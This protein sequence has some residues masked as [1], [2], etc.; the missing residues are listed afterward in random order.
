MRARL[1]EQDLRAALER[2][3]ADARRRSRA[4]RA[5]RQPRSRASASARAHRAR[6]RSP[7][8]RCPPERHA[9][10]VDH[11]A[12]RQLARA[13]D[14]RVADRDRARCAS[15]SAWIEGPPCSRIAPATPAPSTSW[16]FAAFTIA[17]T[18][19]A[20]MSPST[21][22]DAPAHRRASRGA[23]RSAPAGEQRQQDLVVPDQRDS[24][25]RRSASG[26]RPRSPA[27]R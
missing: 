7:R 14:R 12:G 22:H 26:A 13:G 1:L 10:R 17:S 2:E 23:P 25:G 18:A 19:C 15:H 3:A 6:A 4:P 21:Q 11:E 27:G 8:W 16:L 5:S 9:G 24:R 20:V